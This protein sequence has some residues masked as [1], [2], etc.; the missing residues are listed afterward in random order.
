MT[1]HVRPQNYWPGPWAATPAESIDNPNKP[2][3]A[4]QFGAALNAG[5]LSG[6][7]HVIFHAEDGPFDA[8]DADDWPDCSLA[9][10]VP[11]TTGG[12]GN[13]PVTNPG[14]LGKTMIFGNDSDNTNGGASHGD[15]WH[16]ECLGPKPT[17]DMSAINDASPATDRLSFALLFHGYYQIIHGFRVKPARRNPTLTG[18]VSKAAA[19]N[20]NYIDEASHE[21]GMIWV[22]G[23][24]GTTMY[25]CG[26]DDGLF[27]YLGLLF[28]FRTMDPGGSN[29]NFNQN[30]TIEIYN[31]DFGK[32]AA[33]KIGPGSGMTGPGGSVWTPNNS[34]ILIHDNVFRDCYWQGP[35]GINAATYHGNLL[36][37]YGSAMNGTQILVYDN[38]FYGDCQDA[39][40][41]L[42]ANVD[43]FDNDIH[44]ISVGPANGDVVN[45]FNGVLGTT[46][47]GYAAGWNVTTM[48]AKGNGIKCG[49][50]EGYT[51]TSGATGWGSR[52][53]AGGT[54]LMADTH[55]RVYR[56]KI[57]NILAQAIT[58]NGGPGL[59][60]FANEI[61][62]VRGNGITLGSAR[63]A[64]TWHWIAHNYIKVPNISGFGHDAIGVQGNNAAMLFNNIVDSGYR[65]IYVSG[66]GAQAY[67][68]NNRVYGATPAAVSS[69]VLS[70][71]DTY[72]GAIPDYVLGQG[73]VAG[74]NCDKLGTW[75]AI[76][77]ARMPH[78]TK[79]A[80]G[81][82]EWK[83]LA[84]PLGPYQP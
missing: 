70:L 17:F 69:G 9:D 6:D 21:N 15:G 63:T 49:L 31:C 67:G 66:T 53:T 18:R 74:G 77:E 10:T 46:Y 68:S 27:S 75:R 5:S 73:A 37:V 47:A 56:N 84:L 24:W 25:D 80:M 28:E 13:R 48:T 71:T 45:T 19:G 40:V 41:S 8:R 16:F 26:G 50:G 82:K 43:L 72:T 62:S 58:S 23:G 3:T 59:I 7:K 79:H 81:K 65:S 11:I 12:S 22:R 57:R 38:E 42:G 29:Y 60:A 64:V 61:D 54:Y 76:S 55:P 78:I 20:T 52:G 33:N 34:L 83:Y 14:T 30:K 35:V 36:G 4:Y 32:A 39:L 51:G 2:M 44:D 1:Y